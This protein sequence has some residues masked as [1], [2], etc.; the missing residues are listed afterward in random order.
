VNYAIKKLVALGLLSG[1]KQG[2]EVFYS[3]TPAA[4]A[5]VERYRQVR[6]RC[7][8]PT[9]GGEGADRHELQRTADVLRALSG[10]YDQAARAAASL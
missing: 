2:K 5:L 3:T 1:E 6:E 10:V 7:L 4:A 8:L 9:L